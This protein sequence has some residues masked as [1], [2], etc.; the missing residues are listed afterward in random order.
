MYPKS[1]PSRGNTILHWIGYIFDDAWNLTC[2][3][4]ANKL[5]KAE[6]KMNLQ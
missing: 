2:S 3:F 5:V 6:V 4:G 1:G